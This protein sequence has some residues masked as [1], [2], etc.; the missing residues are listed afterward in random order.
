MFSTGRSKGRVSCMAGHSCKKRWNAYGKAEQETGTIQ[1]CQ[2]WYSLQL[3][4]K[5]HFL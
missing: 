2:G 1:T 4:F 5:W 3:L